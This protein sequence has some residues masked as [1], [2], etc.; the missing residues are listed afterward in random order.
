MITRPF[1]KR[2]RPTPQKVTLYEFN[3]IDLTFAHLSP[4]PEPDSSG[5][6]TDS[7]PLANS[8]FD[9]RAAAAVSASVGDPMSVRIEP[10]IGLLSDPEAILE[11]KIYFNVAPRI[12]I[13][14]AKCLA[15]M[16]YKDY[17]PDAAL[18]EFMWPKVSEA[19]MDGSPGWC[20]SY[21]PD[22]GDQGQP[23]GP[24]SDLDNS[25]ISD[26]GYSTRKLIIRAVKIAF[27]WAGPIKI[28]PHFVQLPRRIF[29]G[30]LNLSILSD[31]P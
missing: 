7:R 14:T 16:A 24:R 8:L 15:V 28:H 25:T 30:V 26:C 18:A 11:S 21:G 19:I 17:F 10:R 3:R 27:H 9:G 22:I 6:F 5:S 31:S 29:S 23:N 2:L 20:G 12:F 13:L 4:Y 1:H